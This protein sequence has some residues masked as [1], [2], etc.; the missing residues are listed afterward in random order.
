MKL[1]DRYVVIDVETAQSYDHIIEIA[2][3][4]V[5]GR[6]IS[7]R[8]FVRR[9][10]P[11]S[12]MSPFCYAVH[13]ISLAEL[14]QEPYFNH[15]I[16][17][18]IDFVGD[19]R[20]VAHNYTYEYNTLKR[21]FERA[22]RPTYPRGRFFCTMALAKQSGLPGKLRHACAQAGIGINH[23]RHEHDAL[24]DALL[25]AHLFLKLSATER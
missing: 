17:D 19:D 15:V 20:I 5:I 8:S 18:L 14:E 3:V 11:R 22:E 25:A 9:V 7:P 10:K 12:A 13:R 2:A 21:E 4:E 6:T 16:H 24:N 1:E 23:L